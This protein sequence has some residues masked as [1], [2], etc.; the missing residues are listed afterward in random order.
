MMVHQ[1]HSDAALRDKARAFLPGGSF[2]NVA[3]DLVIA[4][5]SGGRVRDVSR[6]GNTS[7]FCSAPGRCSSATGHP[8][9]IAAVA[10]DQLERGTTFFANSAPVHPPRRGNL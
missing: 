9:V 2:G 1:T 6:A 3:G 5:G 7:I 10:R 4:E 8:E